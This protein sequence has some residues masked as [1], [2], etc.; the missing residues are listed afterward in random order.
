MTG[1]NTVCFCLLRSA[2]C[3]NH[4]KTCTIAEPSDVHLAGT[5]CTAHSQIGLQEEEMAYSFSFFIIWLG[6]RKRLQ[7]PVIVQENVPS[8]P[9]TFFTLHLP[10]WEWSF[11]TLN[12]LELGWPISRDRQWAV[13]GSKLLQST[14]HIIQLRIELQSSIVRCPYMLLLAVATAWDKQKPFDLEP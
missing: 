10:E 3:L 2:Y 5:P 9:R 13:P 7:E 1:P 4:D 12:P 6:M 14:K 11:T 8:F